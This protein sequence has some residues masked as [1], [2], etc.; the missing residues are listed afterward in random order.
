M[1][2]RNKEFRILMRQDVLD[3]LQE[4]ATEQ[5]ITTTRL[6]NELLIT[7]LTNKT[8][9]QEKALEDQEYFTPEKIMEYILKFDKF[10]ED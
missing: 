10:E 5:G 7:Y 3:K 4:Y 9:V 1:V 2:V 6:I 8:D